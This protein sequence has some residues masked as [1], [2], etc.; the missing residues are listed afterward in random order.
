[1]KT[2]PALELRTGATDLILAA[3][4]DF[5]PS[6]V[7]EREEGL[8]V[9]FNSSR[10]RD[11][12]R[13]A[14]APRFPA[15]A[16]DVP[17]E[18]W[19][20]RSQESLRPITI[21]RLTIHPRPHPPIQTESEICNLKSEIPLVIAPSMGFGTGHHATTRMCLEA[22]Q[23]I[24]LAGARVLDV[25]AGSGILAVAAAA[26]GA[27]Q[28]LGVD[29][30]EDA[31]QAARENLARNPG[32]QGVTFEVADLASMARLV[33]RRL[34]AADVVAANLT[35]ALHVRSAAPLLAAARPGGILILSGLQISE[36]DDV[37][38]AFAAAAVV[39]ERTEDEWVCFVMKRA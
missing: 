18:D 31:I 29:T 19:A 20:R 24:D 21:G 32:V 28:A 2:Y 12:A 22:L 6:A 33:E 3:V 8:R 27:A 11:A 14:L 5:S 7:E 30:D 37:R 34:G 15:D 35:G 4:D 23:S 36:R 9:F 16:I 26:L 25:G 17:D 13:A 39:R 38:K 10:D 1:L